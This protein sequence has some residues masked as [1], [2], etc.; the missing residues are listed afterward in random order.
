MC[1]LYYYWSSSRGDF[2]TKLSRADSHLITSR[3]LWHSVWVIEPWVNFTPATF[4][5]NGVCKNLRARH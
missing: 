3:H 4:G 1:R 5:S 2:S